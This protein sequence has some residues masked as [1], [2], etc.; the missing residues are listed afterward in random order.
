MSAYGGGRSIYNNFL[1]RGRDIVFPKDTMM[2][3]GFGNRTS[4][5][6]PGASSGEAR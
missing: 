3:I 2:E 1:G 6:M 4:L 5:P